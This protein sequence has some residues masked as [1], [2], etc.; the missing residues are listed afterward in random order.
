M[1]ALTAKDYIDCVKDDLKERWLTEIIPKWFAI[2]GDTA[3]AR[4]SQKK[5]GLLK[6]EAQLTTGLFCGLSSKVTN[7]L[8]FTTIK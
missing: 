7:R 6:L 5:P 4:Y 1:L 8:S 3:E 2:T